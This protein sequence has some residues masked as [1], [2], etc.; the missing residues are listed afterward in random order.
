MAINLKIKFSVNQLPPYYLICFRTKNFHIFA[1]FHFLNWF[2]FSFFFNYY[3]EYYHEAMGKAFNITAGI[4]YDEGE[5]KQ[6]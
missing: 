2:R 4:P 1:D 3:F 6:L 5:I